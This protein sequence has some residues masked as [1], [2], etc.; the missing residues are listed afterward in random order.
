MSGSPSQ[1]SKRPFEKR[2]SDDQTES[3]K[4]RKANGKLSFQLET[5]R[6][7]GQLSELST[8]YKVESG[9]PAFRPPPAYQEFRAAA[10]RSPHHR[11]L[12]RSP[13]G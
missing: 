5:C 4:P 1:L 11:G 13:R 6:K 12:A 2:L 10:V 8:T 9:K 7:A 3:G